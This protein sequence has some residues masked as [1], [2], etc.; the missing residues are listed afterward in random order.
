MSKTKVLVCG[1][2]GF[3]GR[4]ITEKLVANKN[5]EVHAVRFNRPEYSVSDVT[6]HQADL[7][8]PEDIETVIKGV[9]IIVQ[10]AATTSGSKDI[11][12]KPYIHVTDNAV[13]NSYI[14]RAAFEHKVKHVIFFSCT[15]MYPSS[16]KS[17]KESDDFENKHIERK[18][19]GSAITKLYI[20]KLCEFYA[21]I[22]S[23]KFTAI[24]HSNIYGPHDKYD[25]ERSHFF[26]ATI[27]KVLTSKDEIIVW[28]KGEEKRDLLYIS[29]LLEFVELVIKKQKE[30]YRLYNCGYGEAVSI[31]DLVNKIVN[32]SGKLVKI[33]HDL[34][35]PTIKTSLALD[36][37]LAQQE[38]GWQPRTTLEDG[39]A[40]TIAWWRAN[41]N[42]EKKKTVES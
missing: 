31:K 8:R 7:R 16:E 34:T 38:L 14:F 26:G 21:D 23:A 18:Y 29:D 41:V 9:D 6:W 5:Y 27:T 25:L 13:M 40:K 17:W 4:N 36:C 2:T 24:R 12:N 30:N 32:R 1:A 22:S 10:A 35:K 19:Y 15:V 20:E 37:D 28:G 42:Y 39:I 33:E 3:I 11:L